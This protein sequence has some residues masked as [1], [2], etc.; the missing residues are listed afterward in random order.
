MDEYDEDCEGSARAL[1]PQ[2]V[3]WMGM[4]SSRKLSQGFADTEV[5]RR[6]HCEGSATALPSRR[7]ATTRGD[8]DEAP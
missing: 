6:S 5:E 7:R 3:L 2:T 4:G 1:P 8:G